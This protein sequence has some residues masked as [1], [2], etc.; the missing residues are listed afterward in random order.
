LDSPRDVKATDEAASGLRIVPG[1]WRPH[2]P[3]EQIAWIS[4]PWPSQE[5]VWLDFPEAIFTDAGLLFLSAVNPSF[6]T[7]FTDLPRVAWREENGGL[8][9]SRRLPNGV[10]ISGALAPDGDHV[11]TMTLRLENGSEHPLTD[12]RLQTC[13]YLRAIKEFAAFTSGNKHIH[14]PRDEWLPLEE[15]RQ[16][17]ETGTYRQ[18]FRG[19]GPA[20]ADLPLI[21]TL[22]GDGERL[23]AMTWYED[24]L[25]LGGNP[26]HPCMHADP[27]FP[28]LAP[29][30][31]ASICGEFI[32][33]QGTLSE[34]ERWF[35]ARRR[36]KG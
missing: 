34:F 15:A 12:I 6:P 10:R 14:L 5:Y 20:V 23:L 2:Y 28:D 1:Q 8:R 13:T 16:A 22:S 32:F 19:T 30:Q 7:L 9:Y 29:G 26:Q 31:R 11:V 24:T 4:P 25:S 27:G 3:W 17:P 18:G 36:A 35:L 33:F 21:V